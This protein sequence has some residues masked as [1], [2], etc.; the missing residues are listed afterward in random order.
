MSNT[1]SSVVLSPRYERGPRLK[2]RLVSEVG[3]I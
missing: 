1:V 3:G 2:E